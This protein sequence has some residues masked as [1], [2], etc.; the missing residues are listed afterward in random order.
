MTTGQRVRYRGSEYRIIGFAEGL[1]I[2]GRENDPIEVAIPQAAAFR[3]L[4]MLS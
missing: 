4:T 1:V 3:L 2:I